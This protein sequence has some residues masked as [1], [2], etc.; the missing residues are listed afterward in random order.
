MPRFPANVLPHCPAGKLIPKDTRDAWLA[1]SGPA[2]VD[3]HQLYE[4]SVQQGG[5]DAATP[6]EQW[7]GLSGSLCGGKLSGEQMRQLYNQHLMGFAGGFIV[8]RTELSC[9][10][11]ATSSALVLAFS[12]PGG[13][14]GES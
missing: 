4:L 13:Q 2:K 11:V 8:V 12:L 5:F 1:S 3:L 10:Q 6:Y 9:S 7:A 14:L